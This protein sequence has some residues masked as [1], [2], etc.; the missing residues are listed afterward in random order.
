MEIKVNRVERHYISKFNK[1]YKLIDELCYKSKNIYN[2]ANY[3]IRQEFINNNKWIRY[4]ELAS[5]VKESEPYKDLG[6]NVGQQTLRVLDKNWKSFFES[7]KD[8]SKN[9]DKYLGK[10]KM[11]KYLPK[12]DGRFPLI[13]DNTKVKVLEDGNLRFSWKPLS[14]LNGLYKTKTSGRL[15]QVRFIPQFK[16]CVMEIVYEIEVPDAIQKTNRI[17]GIDIGIDNLA[18]VAN[19][20]KEQPFIING[21]PLKSINQYYNKRKGILQSDLKTKHNKNWSNRLQQLADKRNSKIKD[22]LHKSSRWIIDWCIENRIDTI[23][24]GRNKNWKQ[25]VQMGRNNNQNFTQ[26]PMGILIQQIKYKAENVGIK[27]I[28]TEESYTSGTSFLDEELPIKK[29]YNKNRRVTRGLFKSNSGELIN[30]DLNG[31]YQIIKKVFPNTFDDG[32]EGVG[33]HPVRINV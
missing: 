4:N 29:H 15:L 1:N 26:I 31:A 20:I 6:S 9:K 13:I 19:N 30:A 22:Y 7:I 16:A 23:V 12:E 8:W 21:R 14:F 2:Y 28:E 32:I 25:G 11:P 3:L 10:P 33:L 5:V 18:T 27:V 24:V 17:V